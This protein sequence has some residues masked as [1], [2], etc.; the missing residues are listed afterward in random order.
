MVAQEMKRN[1]N[2]NIATFQAVPVASLK[3][4]VEG[5]LQL[6]F[7]ALLHSSFLPSVSAQ[8]APCA[9]FGATGM[10]Y[11]SKCLVQI[12]AR[13]PRYYEAGF[14]VGSVSRK[15]SVLPFPYS[16]SGECKHRI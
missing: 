12:G 2:M 14:R 7:S 1:S 3:M 11:T 13:K 6:P 10:R 9:A 8:N 5:S 15:H 4:T 16:P